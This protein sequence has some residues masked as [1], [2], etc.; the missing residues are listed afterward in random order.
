MLKS[1]ESGVRGRSKRDKRKV[2]VLLRLKHI[3]SPSAHDQR[4]THAVVALHSRLSP[5]LVC[6]STANGRRELRNSRGRHSKCK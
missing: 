6:H 4:A 5:K 3:G 2:P 1:L